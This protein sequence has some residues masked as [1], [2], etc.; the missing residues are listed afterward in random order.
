MHKHLNMAVV[1]IVLSFAN[2]NVLGILT[3]GYADIALLS[4][5]LSRRSQDQVTVMSM[6]NNVLEDLPQGIIRVIYLQAELR[7]SRPPSF[8]DVAGLLTSGLMLL[9]GIVR[10]CMLGLILRHGG[11][12]EDGGGGRPRS[13]RISMQDFIRRLTMDGGDYERG[14]EDG[15]VMN[16]LGKT[17]AAD[18]EEGDAEEREA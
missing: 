12:G 3:A 1:V 7:A 15:V 6:T 14:E 11:A 10:R 16:P 9:I 8:I 4:A 2:P 18:V 17:K 13:R 5:P